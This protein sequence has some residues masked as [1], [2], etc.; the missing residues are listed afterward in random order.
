MGN[1]IIGAGI[2][3]LPREL[4]ALLGGLS[5]LG[6]LLAG[7]WIL[8]VAA[9][10][11]EVSSRFDE[12]GGLYLYARHAFGQFTGLLVAWLSWLTR[13]AAPAAAANLFCTYAAQF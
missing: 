10:I 5:P 8:I 3:G 2:F 9:C 4:A 11:A 13:I 1:S 12:T 6:C 7:A